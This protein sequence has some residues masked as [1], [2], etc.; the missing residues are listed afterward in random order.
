VFTTGPAALAHIAGDRLSSRL[1]RRFGAW[2]Y[3]PGAFKVDFA[4]DGPIPWEAPGLAEAGTVHVGGTFEEV[5]GAERLVAQGV[6]PER[7]F[8]LLAQPSIGDPTRAPDGQHAVWAYCHVPTG[9]EVDMT[10]RIED[11]IERF[12]PGFQDRILARSVTTP[13][14]LESANPNLVG[15]DV[16]GGS[17]AGTRMVFRPSAS[18]HPHRVTES[19]FLGSASTPPG[20]GVHGMGGY[21]AAHEALKGPLR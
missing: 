1:R 4:L 20:G 8:V 7:P 13:R 21:W 17:H 5:A 14:G 18:V 19:I 6:H 3:G 10:D 2:R 15:G 12:A 16:G 9:S 11:Q